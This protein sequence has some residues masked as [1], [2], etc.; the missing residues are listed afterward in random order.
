MSIDF[1]DLRKDTTVVHLVQHDLESLYWV[2]IWIVLRHTEHTHHNGVD[3]CRK[4]F[5]HDDEE[6]CRSQKLQWLASE[7]QKFAVR[8]NRPLT[9]LLAV[10]TKLVAKAHND[11]RHPLEYDTIIRLFQRTLA[12]DAWPENDTAIPYKH[13]D[14]SKEVPVQQRPDIGVPGSTLGKRRA[15]TELQQSSSKRRRVFN[16]TRGC[17]GPI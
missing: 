9:I 3:A 13:I 4:L 1:L 12:M 16:S 11:R 17:T 8:D 10:F 6:V 14:T 15:D 7:R 5:D 2:F